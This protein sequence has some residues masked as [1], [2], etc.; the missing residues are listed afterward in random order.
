LKAFPLDLYAIV[1]PAI[2]AEQGEIDVP[3]SGDDGYTPPSDALDKPQNLA[4][5]GIGQ[6]LYQL[7]DSVGN[8]HMWLRFVSL[9]L[10]YPLL[11]QCA[12]E[13]ARRVPVYDHFDDRGHVDTEPFSILRIKID[14]EHLVPH[15]LQLNREGKGPGSIYPSLAPLALRESS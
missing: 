14:H 1:A 5:L 2:L 15:S 10:V 4:C 7:I 9:L 13:L 12:A 3:L 6:S 11:L 8:S